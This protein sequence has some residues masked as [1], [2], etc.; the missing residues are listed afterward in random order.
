MK[1][2][3]F[4]KHWLRSEGE[5]SSQTMGQISQENSKTV[6]LLLVQVRDDQVDQASNLIAK[7][8]ESI[9]AADGTV[10]HIISSIVIAT[11]DFGFN[12]SDDAEK[13]CEA[14]AHSVSQLLQND[15]KILYGLHAAVYGN[16]GTPTRM[17]YGPFIRD[18]G[19][20]LEQL[21]NLEFGGTISRVVA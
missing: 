2:H 11:F 9:L 3:Q 8:V 4:E 20:L 16:F 14:A 6:P 19:N 5:Q 7:T 1:K 17:H 13:R 15:G 10:F 21:R 18:I 12:N